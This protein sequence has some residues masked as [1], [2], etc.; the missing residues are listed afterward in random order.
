[1]SALRQFI[2]ITLFAICLHTFSSFIPQD[3]MKIYLMRKAMSLGNKSAQIEVYFFNDWKENSSLALEATYQEMAPALMKEAKVYFIDKSVPGLEPFARA[4]HSVL[5]SDDNKNYL[6]VRKAL[7]ELITTSPQATDEE[8]HAQ[9]ANAGINYTSMPK[10]MAD[11]CQKEVC[12]RLYTHFS[13][14]KCPSVVIVK[15]FDPQKKIKTAP[16]KIEKIEDINQ[17]SI[18]QIINSLK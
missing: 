3:L 4:N 15:L 6:A 12:D 11:F 18:S 9:L 10:E 16:I 5:A 1:M 17:S 13:L 7:L 8:I 14:S 2:H